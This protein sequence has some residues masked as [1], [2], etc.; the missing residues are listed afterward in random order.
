M[1]PA[2]NF[3]P[4]FANLAALHGLGGMP[5]PIRPVAPISFGPQMEVPSQMAAPG[6]PAM[7]AQQPQMP[8]QSPYGPPA[9]QAGNLNNLRAIL[10]LLGQR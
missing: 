7:A 2:L 4:S 8:M 9:G 1:L 3:N 5:H 10:Q 6:Y